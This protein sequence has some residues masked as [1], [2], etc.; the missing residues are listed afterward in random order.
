MLK[1][2][3]V[4]G[5]GESIPSTVWVGV[6]VAGLSGYAAIAILL[7]LLARV[8][9]APFGLYCIAVGSFAAYVL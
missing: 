9:L 8:G 1:I 4:I 7:R 2:I 6:V 3:E 5:A